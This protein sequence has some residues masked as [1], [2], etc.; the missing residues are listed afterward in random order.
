MKKRRIL[1]DW[2]AQVL[3]LI[4]CA[5]LTILFGIDE[6][7]NIGYTILFLFTSLLIDFIL[8]KVLKKYSRVLEK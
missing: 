2:V 1:K 6:I 8:Y 7:I 5:N 3:L 4:L